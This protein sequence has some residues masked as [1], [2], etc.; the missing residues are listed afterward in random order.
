MLFTL[1][2]SAVLE[3]PI[4]GEPGECAN[5]KVPFKIFPSASNMESSMLFSTSSKFCQVNQTKL[6]LHCRWPNQL[7]KVLIMNLQLIQ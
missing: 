1:E 3:N 4:I 5:F 7:Q 2:V 6:F